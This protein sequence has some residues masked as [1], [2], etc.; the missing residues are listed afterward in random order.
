MLNA[1]AAV[2]NLRKV[3]ASEF[4]LLLETEWTVIG[5]DDLQMIALKAVPELF[6]MPLFAKRRRKN[7]FR[8][9]KVGNIKVFDREIQILGASFGIDGKAAVAR[10]TNF[11]KSLIAAQDAR[12]RSEL[13]PSPLSAIAR[14]TASASAVVGRV[15]A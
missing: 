13:P 9:F 2:G 8:A 11:F 1:R 6:L 3:V 14:D 4:F 10:L 12:C 15:S 7:V 5:R